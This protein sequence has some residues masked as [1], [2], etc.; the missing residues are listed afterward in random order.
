MKL[1]LMRTVFEFVALKIFLPADIPLASLKLIDKQKIILR[2]IIYQLM[3]YHHCQK[4]VV[5]TK[6]HVKYLLLL[7]VLI[8]F[9]LRQFWI[10]HFKLADNPKSLL[11]I[12][13]YTVLH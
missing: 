3:A 1:K 9:S 4:L 8:A 7:F 2:F 12:D 10:W 6:L 13:S 5:L 11:V